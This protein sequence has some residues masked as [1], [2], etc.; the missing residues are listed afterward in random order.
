MLPSNRQV[1]IGWSM[2][3]H[4]IYTNVSK[5][6]EDIIEKLGT[7]RLEMEL[8][9]HNISHQSTMGEIMRSNALKVVTMEADSQAVLDGLITALQRLIRNINRR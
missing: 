8:S 5:A 9:S 2:Y 3:S 6:T 1:K 7:E 4:P